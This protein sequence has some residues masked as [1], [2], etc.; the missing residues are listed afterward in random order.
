MKRLIRKAE[1]ITIYHGT[2]LLSLDEILQTGIAAGMIENS[3]WTNTN[4]AQTFYTTTM[5]RAKY[6]G[7]VKY[8]RFGRRMN[9]VIVVMEI[10]FDTDYLEPDKDDVPNATTWQESDEARKQVAFSGSVVANQIQKLY[11]YEGMNDDLIL[12]CT[13]SEY[14][15]DP[16]AIKE[17]IYNNNKEKRGEIDSK[18]AEEIADEMSYMGEKIYKCHTILQRYNEN[19]TVETLQPKLDR[20]YRVIYQIIEKINRL[21]AEYNEETN[22]PI[23]FVTVEEKMEKPL[24]GFE[25]ELNT[26]FIDWNGFEACTTIHFP[27]NSSTY[28]G[29]SFKKY[30][31]QKQYSKTAKKRLTKTK[32]SIK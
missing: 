31:K 15:S 9:D 32:K 7:S 25:S 17:K 12:E 11:F 4:S 21:I 6:Y 5:D 2:N 13:T 8:Y 14:L 24:H 10:D 19:D 27:L 28:I 23:P 29:D 1:P 22:E 26:L 30:I 20:E 18:K 16:E 3:T